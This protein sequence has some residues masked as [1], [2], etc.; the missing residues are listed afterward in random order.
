MYT[1]TQEQMNTLASYI[2]HMNGITAVDYMDFLRSFKPVQQIVEEKEAVEK[3]PKK[4]E[5]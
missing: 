2:K 1:L 4:E 3:T 5:K